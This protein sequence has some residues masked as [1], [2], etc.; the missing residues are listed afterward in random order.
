MKTRLLDSC[1]RIART[2]LVGVLCCAL[3]KGKGETCSKCV[4][5]LLILRHTKC[6][7]FE[8]LCSCKSPYNNSFYSL[9]SA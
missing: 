3:Q 1:A 6:N 5:Y 8:E 7:A 2:N 9:T 4:L